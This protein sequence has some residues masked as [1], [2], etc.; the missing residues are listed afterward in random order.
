R[1]ED[2]QEE[3]VEEVVA[4]VKT[5]TRDIVTIGIKAMATMDITAK[6]TVVMEDMTTLVTTTT[7]DMVIIATSRVAMGKYPGEAA[8]K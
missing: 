6:V 7:M 4:P 2:L 3:L 1:E 8:I 5:G